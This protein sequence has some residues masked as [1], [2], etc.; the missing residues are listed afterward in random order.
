VEFEMELLRGEGTASFVMDHGRVGPQGAE[1]GSDGA[2]TEVTVYRGD[3][4]YHPPHFSKDQGIRLKTGDR[5]E[6][7]TPGGGGYGDPAKRD[8][9]AIARDL[10]RGYYTPD[11][12]RE[13]FG[14]DP[15]GLSEA[16]E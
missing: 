9:A 8:R 2:P 10:K 3:E 7:K 15:D 13:K 6:V 12:I 14:I 11:D 5:V 16:A 4:T 1:G